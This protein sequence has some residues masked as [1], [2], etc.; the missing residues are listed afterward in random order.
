MGNLHAGHVSLTE[1]A[2]G[3]AQRV[4]AS[5]FVNPTQF[6]PSEDFAA[7]PRTLEEDA[8]RLAAAGTVDLLFVPDDREIYPFGHRAGRARHA[9]A[10]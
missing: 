10:A 1:L 9:A 5:I 8:A 7:Y 3:A 6:G 4:V 2:A